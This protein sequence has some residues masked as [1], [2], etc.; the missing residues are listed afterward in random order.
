ME[1]LFFRHVPCSNQ[2][3]PFPFSLMLHLKSM[4]KVVVEGGELYSETY[5]AVFITV[6]GVFKPFDDVCY[7]LLRRGVVGRRFD[8]VR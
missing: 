3:I 8:A 7:Q 4:C 1:N 6:V 5:F 2:V